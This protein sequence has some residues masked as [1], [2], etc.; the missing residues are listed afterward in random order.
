[1]LTPTRVM[2]EELVALGDVA[3]VVARRPVITGVQDDRPEG[4]PRP[5]R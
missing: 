4:R 3:T 5:G 1:M 2:V